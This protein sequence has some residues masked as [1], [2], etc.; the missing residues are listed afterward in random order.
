MSDRL[1]LLLHC[2]LSTKRYYMHNAVA[3]TLIHLIK[4]ISVGLMDTQVR[5]WAGVLV[6]GRRDKLRH[7]QAAP[8]PDTQRGGIERNAAGSLH[9]QSLH[10]ESH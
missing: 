3:L 6:S 1:G 7:T 4:H 9:L 2:I 8:G 5:W 10:L